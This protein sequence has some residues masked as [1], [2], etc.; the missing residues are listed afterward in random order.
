MLWKNEKI[1]VSKKTQ[2]KKATLNVIL[3]A[4]DNY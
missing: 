2:E 1:Q 3:L 4:S